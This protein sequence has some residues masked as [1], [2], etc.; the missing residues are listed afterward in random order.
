[1]FESDPV[2]GFAY[3]RA[4]GRPVWLAGC[5][6]QLCG[7]KDCLVSHVCVGDETVHAVV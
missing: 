1:M 5:C 3:V 4:A 6:V 2:L 7:A